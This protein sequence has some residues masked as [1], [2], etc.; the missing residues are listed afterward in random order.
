V[1][2]SVVLF[3]VLGLGLLL[4]WVCCWRG[5]RALGYVGLVVFGDV[6]GVGGEGACWRRHCYPGGVVGF[7]TAGWNRL[8]WLRCGF[9]VVFLVLGLVLMPMVCLVLPIVLGMLFCCRRGRGRGGVCWRSYSRCRYWGLGGCLWGTWD[10]RC[11]RI[12]GSGS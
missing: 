2:A 12:W 9:P 10:S 4:F 6:W 3:V 5:L 7:S 8:C 1:L 11:R